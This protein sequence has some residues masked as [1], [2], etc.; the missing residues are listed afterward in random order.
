MADNSTTTQ[1]EATAT[2]TQTQGQGQPDPAVNP[3]TYTQEEC[4]AIAAKEAGKTDRY[5]CRMLGI[6]SRDEVQ[7]TLDQI[8]AA[9]V[10]S[11]RAAQAEK[12]RD[13]LRTKYDAA[14][15]ELSALKNAKTL[16]AYGVTDGD[17]QEFLVYKISKLAVNGKTFEDAAKEYF[18][19]HPRSRVSVQL[20]PQ[21]QGAAPT[22]TLNDKINRM[23]RGEK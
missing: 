22:T 18:A 20:T 17:E 12:D 19:A 13:E 4:N 6:S 5:W 14:A 2:T 15:L 16:T 7:G 8:K 23:L 1:A 11:A 3:R 10:L 21:Q 9:G